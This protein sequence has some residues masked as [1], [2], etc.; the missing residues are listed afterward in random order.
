MKNGALLAISP[1]EGLA[2]YATVGWTCFQRGAWEP[3]VERVLRELLRPGDTA[4]DV[5]ANLGYFSA[6]MAQAVGAAGRVIA[7]EPV[8]ETFARLSI[9][10]E[11][12]A[13]SQL[14]I[15]QIAAGASS[16]TTIELAVDPR[17]PGEASAYCRPDRLEPV[18]MNVPVCRL[19][20]LVEAN[21]MPPPA[22]VKIDVE[23]HELAV[24]KGATQIL[25][26]YR[27]S[28]VFELNAAMSKE[29]GWDASDVAAFLQTSAPYCFFLLGEGDPQPVELPDLRL[30]GSSYVDILARV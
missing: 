5:G 20:D 30:E 29:A 8:P 4:Y 19:D 27:P 16:E 1:A 2:P 15:L 24:L 28:L 11:L 14:T 25:K 3:H 22:L 13:Y 26:S 6:V 18:R 17:L 23:G 10:K 9:S 7:L 21:D 12:N